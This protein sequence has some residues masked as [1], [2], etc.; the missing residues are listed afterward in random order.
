MI[1]KIKA[2]FILCALLVLFSGCDKSEGKG[3][4][5]SIEGKVLVQ[6]YS[7]TGA[8]NGTPQPAMNYKVFLIYGN[9]TT[10]SDD[11]NTS[12]DGSYQFLNLKKGTYKVFVYSTIYPVPANPPKEEAIMQTV[13]ISDKKG[14][15]TVPTITVNH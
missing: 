6:D 11:F 12:Y 1:S 4:A 10:Y 5:A 3:G 15:V 8:L 13:T 7:S 14:I 2:A 9:G